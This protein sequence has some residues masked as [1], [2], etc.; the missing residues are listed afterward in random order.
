M[1]FASQTSPAVRAF[2]TPATRRA[3]LAYPLRVIECPRPP[4]PRRRSRIRRWLA[5]V[6]LV[7]LVLVGLLGLCFAIPP[8]RDFIIGQILYQGDFFF[9]AH[10]RTTVVRLV[11][12]HPGA[13]PVPKVVPVRKGTVLSAQLVSPVL[14]MQHRSYRIY[15]PPGYGQ[16]ANRGRRYPVLYLIH[17]WPGDSTSWLRGAHV[18]YAAN[19]AIAAGTIQ[20]L[21][22]VMP[23]LSGDMWRDTE[24]VNK[25][26]GSDNEMDYFVRD[27]VRYIDAHYRTI[28]D[29]LHRA[30]GGLSSGGYCAF[31]V[32]L[33]YPHLFNTVFAM[34]AYFHA[35]RGEVFGFNDPF[36]HNPGFLAAN[37]PD[38]Y[39]AHVPGVRHMHLFLI[40][41]TADWGFTGF[42]TR[43]DRQLNRLHIRHVLIMRHP[44]GFLVLDHA[45]AFWSSAFR[46]V[47]PAISASFGH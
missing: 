5:R 34:S 10:Q 42:T 18:D 17:G 37:S 39:V 38:D 21:I 45:W 13:K 25:W 40:G 7:F 28:P 24:C 27:V 41:S 22:L 3:D 16:V 4:R 14:H 2:A 26:N 36:G 8:A 35:L 30:I 47:L 23:D 32:G 15:L 12:P 44:K 29:R 9:P 6:G 31:N 20:P 33:H 46:Q 43:F 1:Q 19:E 11:Q